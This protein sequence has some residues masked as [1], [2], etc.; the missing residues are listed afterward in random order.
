[1]IVGTP[2]YPNENMLYAANIVANILDPGN[3][4]FID[5]AKKYLRTAINNESGYILA[6]TKTVKEYYACTIIEP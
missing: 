6:G 4:G 5:V 2:D 1:M 3:N